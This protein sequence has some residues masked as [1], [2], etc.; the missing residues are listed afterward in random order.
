MDMRYIEERFRDYSMPEM[1]NLSVG[2]N[3]YEEGNARCKTRR[4]WCTYVRI[5][6]SVRR[7]ASRWERKEMGK[8]SQ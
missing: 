6:M 7:K 5:C 2:E 1:N 8:G 3:M 4:S